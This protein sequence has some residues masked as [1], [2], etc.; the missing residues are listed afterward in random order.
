MHSS[1][2]ARSTE[3]R[4][5]ETP[6]GPNARSAETPRVLVV[7]NYDSFVY[8]L[9]QYLAQLGASVVVRRNDVVEPDELDDCDAVLVSP[10]PGTPERAGRSMEVIARA[11]ERGQPVLGV[12]L[13]H[14]AIGAVWG[15]VIERA[16]ELL[17]GKTSL[18]YHDRVGVLVDLPNPF[19]ATR[20][21]S[22]TIRPSSVPP[23]LEVTGRTESGVIMAVRHRGLPVQGVQFH[24]ESVLTEGGHRMLA[25]WLASCGYPVPE[26]TIAHLTAEAA[27]LLNPGTRR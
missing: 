13:G 8:N 17:H 16:P 22:L 21:H 19:T 7:D 3:T 18:V 10:G 1:A 20:Y 14:Q 15:G 26:P 5:A 11:A 24:P 6:R 25:N 9:V 2:D 27:A 12:C 4:S 23:E